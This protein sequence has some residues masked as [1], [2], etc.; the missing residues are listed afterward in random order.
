MNSQMVAKKDYQFWHPMTHPNN[1]VD[2]TP[3]RIVKGDGLF[4][5]DDKGRKMLDG[6]AG[7]WCVNVGHNRAEVKQAINQQMDELA[8]Y[9]LFDGVSHPKAE[10]LSNKLI[11]MTAQEKYGTSAIWDRRLGWC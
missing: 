4:I 9:Q 8:Y 2:K 3:L 10:A 5:W 11:E 1:W 7:L 6:F